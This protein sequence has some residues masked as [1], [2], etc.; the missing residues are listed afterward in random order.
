MN[1][2][3]ILHRIE[4]RLAELG[5]SPRAASLKAKLSGDAIRNWQRRVSTDPTRVGINASSLEAVARAL[6]VDM[7]WLMQGGTA[8]AQRAQPGLSEEASPYI[9]S[10]P[11][12]PN[13]IRALFS[14]RARNAAITHRAIVDMP[15]F[16][17]RAGD[18]MVCDLAR[19]PETDEVALA[20]SVDTNAGTS[21]TMVRRYVPPFLISGDALHPDTIELA[22]ANLDLRHPVIGVIRGT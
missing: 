22:K 4:T 5:M 11:I 13:P 20:V 2:A 1:A 8:E 15:G 17:I 21:A 18:L 16:D 9:P 3:A 6:D 14:D 12:D 7:V 19:L 10:A